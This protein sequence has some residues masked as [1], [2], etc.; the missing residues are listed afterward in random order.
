MHWAIS[1]LR[2]TPRVNYQPGLKK[3]LRSVLDS[4][5]RQELTLPDGS[6]RKLSFHLSGWDQF[7]ITPRT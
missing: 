5:T 7:E 4:C 1:L 3:I 2:K 6:G